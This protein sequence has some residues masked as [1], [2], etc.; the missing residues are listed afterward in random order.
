LTA[1]RTPYQLEKQ[2]KKKYFEI[3][4]NGMNRTTKKT[5]PPRNEEDSFYE[6]VFLPGK[7]SGLLTLS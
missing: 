3:S 1:S 2:Q 4:W 7:F 6:F 5:N